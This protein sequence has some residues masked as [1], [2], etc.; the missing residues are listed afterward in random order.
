M[1]TWAAKT[2]LC[3]SLY[4]YLPISRNECIILSIFEE[5]NDSDWLWAAIIR[6]WDLRIHDH[7]TPIE[8]VLKELELFKRENRTLNLI[9]DEAHKLTNERAFSDISYLSNMC[10]LSSICFNVILIGNSQLKDNLEKSNLTRNSTSYINEIK[11]LQDQ[12]R[13]DYLQY[14]FKKTE[15]EAEIITP[16]LLS[17]IDSKTDGTIKSLNQISKLVQISET[18]N[19][20]ESIAEKLALLPDK[21]EYM[22]PKIAFSQKKVAIRHDTEKNEKGISNVF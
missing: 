8:T 5:K 12:D 1:V 11:E 7:D 18:K 13:I 6:Q 17:L 14:E 3:R 16:E 22:A 15:L 2:T 9:I 10:Q 4:E 21:R 19:T 20:S